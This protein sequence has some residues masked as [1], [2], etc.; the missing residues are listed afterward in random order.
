ME[1]TTEEIRTLITEQVSRLQESHYLI[2]YWSAQGEGRGKK[3]NIT[4]IFDDLK[5]AGITRTKQ[6]AVAAVTALQTLCFLDVREEANRKNVYITRAGGKA[7]QEMLTQ[8]RYQLKESNYL[9]EK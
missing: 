9:K 4:N 5:S 6:T 3:Y 8:K 2:L 1:L 7:L